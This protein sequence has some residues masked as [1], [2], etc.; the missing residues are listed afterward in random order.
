MFSG[1]KIV[2]DAVRTNVTVHIKS[3]DW[4]AIEMFHHAFLASYALYG[5]LHN[6][7]RFV[8]IEHRKAVA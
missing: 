3:G 2:A 5:D 8:Y 7:M 1:G 4:V 6:P